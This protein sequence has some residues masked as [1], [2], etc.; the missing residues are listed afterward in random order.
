MGITHFR[1]QHISSSIIKY[2]AHLSKPSD[3]VHIKRL[4]TSNFKMPPS[5]SQSSDPYLNSSRPSPSPNSPSTPSEPLTD[6]AQNPS[7]LTA[8]HKPGPNAYNFHSDTITTPTLSMLNAITATTLSDDIYTGDPTTSSLEHDIAQL[9]GHEA[10]LLVMSGTMG[11]Q[12]S[13][14]A[15]LTSPPHS[16]LCDYRA[17]I[18]KYEAGGIATL[19]GAQLITV[20]PSNNHHLTL[21]DIEREIILSDDVHACPT[22]LI[23]LENTLNGTIM[24]LSEVKRISAYARSRGIILHLDGAR[25]WEA[26]AA[27]SGTLTEYCSLFDSASLCFSKGLGAPIGSLI[28]GN[29]AFIKRAKWIRKM[30]GGSTRQSGI[31][32]AAARVAVDE[33]FG[34]GPSGEGGRLRECHVKAKK[35]AKLWTEELGGKL[36]WPVETNMVWLDL[37]GMGLTTGEVERIAKEEGIVTGGWRIVIHYQICE[38]ALDALERTLRRAVKERG[39]NGK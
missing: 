18:W 24:P 7:L 35:V 9:A 19:S 13:I 30:F 11:N 6:L 14:R 39:R 1:Y 34:K 29:T 3:F 2:T 31:I 12:V 15:H 17:H 36:A 32:A 8:W 33:G 10:G 37:E 27:S 25:I 28:V 26:V 16:V 5:V 21:E 20:R 38:E 23:S 22:K 4:T